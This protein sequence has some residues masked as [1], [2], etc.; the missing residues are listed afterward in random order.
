MSEFQVPTHEIKTPLGGNVVV[1][2]DYISGYDDEAI[3][4]IYTKGRHKISTPDPKNPDKKSDNTMEFEGSAIQEAER[5]GVTR[6]VVSVDGQT[7]NILDRVYGMRADDTKFVKK[8]VD[9]VVNPPEDT[10]EK[11]PSGNEPTPA[12]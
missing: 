2:K 8:Q 6:V 4:S 10:P 12:S 7:D 5:E 1:L 11:K 3:E 9:L